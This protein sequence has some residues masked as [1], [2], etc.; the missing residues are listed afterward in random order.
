[1]EN[2]NSYFQRIDLTVAVFLEEI[3]SVSL[4]TL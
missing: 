1:V 4:S 2:R 3:C